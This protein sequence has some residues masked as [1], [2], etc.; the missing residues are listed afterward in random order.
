VI[1]VLTHPSVVHHSL[2]AQL[3]WPSK[4]IRDPGACYPDTPRRVGKSG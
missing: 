4:A 1:I 2:S 3:R